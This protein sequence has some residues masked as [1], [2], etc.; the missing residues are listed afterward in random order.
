MIDSTLYTSVYLGISFKHMAYTGFGDPGVV[1]PLLS[2][3]AHFEVN[4]AY[5]KPKMSEKITEL[6]III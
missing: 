2:N 4:L 3:H 5:N 6:N 1:L